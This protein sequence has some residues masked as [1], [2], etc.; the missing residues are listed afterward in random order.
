MNL[1]RIHTNSQWWFCV[2]KAEHTDDHVLLA[3][4]P[5]IGCYDIAMRLTGDEVRL[6]QTAPEDFVTLARDFVA[7]RDMPIFCSRHISYQRN[8]LDFL[9]IEDSF[10]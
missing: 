5:G 8:G 10:S 9:E 4:V 2:F 7:S 3:T 6:Y 1:R